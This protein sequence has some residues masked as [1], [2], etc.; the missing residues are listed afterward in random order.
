METFASRLVYTSFC[1]ILTRATALRVAEFN[2]KT[3]HFG[4]I[5]FNKNKRMN[6]NRKSTKN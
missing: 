3:K 5:P 1:I 4:V 6:I 2:Q